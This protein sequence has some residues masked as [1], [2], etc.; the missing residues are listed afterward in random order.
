MLLNKTPITKGSFALTKGSIALTKGSFALTKGS[1]A[2]T[3][4]SIALTMEEIQEEN[5]I[6]LKYIHRTPE[7]FLQIF[8][9]ELLDITV[10]PLCIVF[11]VYKIG[12]KTL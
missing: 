11:I 4:G 6:T 8:Y 9:N 12:L 5:D 3:K 7:N 10:I 1:I 2:L